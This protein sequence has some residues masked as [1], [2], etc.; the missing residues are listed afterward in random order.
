MDGATDTL[1]S[2]LGDMMGADGLGAVVQPFLPLFSKF[3]GKA[4]EGGVN[5][6]L[7]YRLG[8]LSVSAFRYLK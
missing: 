4:A 8:R 5:A 7:A 1:N 6:Y 2:N 3:V